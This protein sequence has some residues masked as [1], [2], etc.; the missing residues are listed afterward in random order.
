MFSPT[1]TNHRIVFRAEQKRLRMF[2]QR[3]TLSMDQVQGIPHNPLS[4]SV[5]VARRHRLGVTVPLI[6]L[7]RYLGPASVRPEK[8]CPHLC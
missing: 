3:L 1:D 8:L 7:R 4:V 6:V 5:S 2:G